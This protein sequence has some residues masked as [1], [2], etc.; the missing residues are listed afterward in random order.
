MHTSIGVGN[1]G[2][3]LFTNE[4]NNGISSMRRTLATAIMLALSGRILAYFRHIGRGK[5][6]GVCTLYRILTGASNHQMS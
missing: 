6:G 2:L 1:R 4:A 3:S 5:L